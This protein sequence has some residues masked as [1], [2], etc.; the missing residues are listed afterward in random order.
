V[1]L[2]FET[3]SGIDLKKVGSYNYS[4]HPSFRI[5][6][7]LYLLDGE[8]TLKKWIGFH[9]DYFNPGGTATAPDGLVEAILSGEEIVGW[10]VSFERYCLAWMAKRDER[11]AGIPV[12]QFVCTMQQA[13][14]VGLPLGLG[15]CGDAMRCVVTKDS[16]GKKVMQQTAKPRNGVSPKGSETLYLAARKRGSKNTEDRPPLTWYLRHTDAEKFSILDSYCAIDVRSEVD[17]GRAIPDMP[18]GE[19]RLATVDREINSRGLPID[20]PAVERALELTAFVK[21]DADERLAEL[22]EGAVTSA[23]QLP[24]L[25]AWLTANDCEMESVTKSTIPEQLERDDLPESVRKV[26]ELRLEGGA[27]SLKKLLKM[28]QL[29][30]DDGTIKDQ[31]QY[32]GAHTGRW[33]GRGAQPQNFFK[34]WGAPE[35][36]SGG[37]KFGPLAFV[38]GTPQQVTFFRLLM[39]DIPIREVAASLREEFGDLVTA[40]KGALRGFIKAPPGYQLYVCDFA[41]IENRVLAW[42]A[43]EQPLLEAFRKNEDPYILTASRIYGVEKADVT[44]E[45]RSMGKVAV[46]AAQFGQGPRGFKN[47][48]QTPWGITI[49]M[50]EARA[51]IKAYRDSN[52]AI[53]D[54]WYDLYRACMSSVMTGDDQIVGHLTTQYDG[55]SLQIKLPTGRKLHYWNPVVKEEKAVWSW[56]SVKLHFKPTEDEVVEWGI[57]PLDVDENTWKARDCD[58][59]FF[60]EVSA[61]RYTTGEYHPKYCYQ[62]YH[63]QVSK[64]GSKKWCKIHDGKTN[65]HHSTWPGTLSEN[66][67]QAV[68]REALAEAVLRVER[69]FFGTAVDD[70]KAGLIGYVHD[71]LVALVPDSIGDHGAGYS[72]FER[73]MLQV[74]A[75]ATGLPISGE[76][77]VATRYRK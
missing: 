53:K 7:L 76:G 52:P 35:K 8:T 44:K 29:C 17:L 56:T 27:A 71:E 65:R 22:T 62:L 4:R 46:L 57:P 10:N 43:G 34:G 47:T 55:K 1:N 24:K 3:A 48:C 50:G 58:R 16:D 32:S 20:L 19:R 66:V 28:K 12:E 30:T 15:N 61:D 42:L 38:E 49:S 18:A 73:I 67:T 23:T 59:A 6:T 21:E 41:G 51:T 74:P 69:D 33:S 13:A 64:G 11:L 9:D 68:A 60:E 2:D 75:W 14:V 40:C 36:D 45:Q 37:N 63:E 31:F 25:K 26:L 72:E 39:Q 5:T 54:F 77:Y 70:A